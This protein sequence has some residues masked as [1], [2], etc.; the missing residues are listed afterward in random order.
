I[1]AI[2]FFEKNISDNFYLYGVGWNKPKKFNL[3]EKILGFKRYS[4]YKGEVVDK[5]ETLSNFKY[6]LCFENLANVNGYVT[7]KII[8][9]FKAKCIPIYWG[10]S[11]IE[12]YVPKDCFID[13]RDFKDYKKL[14]TYLESIDEKKYTNYIENIERLLIDK[15][16]TEYWFENGFSKFFLEDVLDIRDELKSGN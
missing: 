11:N 6:C 12:K 2:D 9:C 15:K 5:I 16:F 13:F 3:K 1:K 7:E 14:L 8:D 4:T 10:A